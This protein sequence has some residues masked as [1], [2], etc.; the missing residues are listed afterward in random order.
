MG[1]VFGASYGTPRSRQRP[2]LPRTGTRLPP[3]PRWAPPC[4]KAG[5][6]GSQAAPG[7]QPPG[8][9]SRRGVVVIVVAGSARDARGAWSGVHSWRGARPSGARPCGARRAGNTALR[10][11]TGR[12]GRRAGPRTAGQA[13]RAT[14]LVAV[15]PKFGQDSHDVSSAGWLLRMPR[16]PQPAGLHLAAPVCRGHEACPAP[17]R[18]R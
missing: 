4:V 9:P 16:P 14:L 12:R 10:R 15:T 2:L 5:R 1:F 7:L 8:P 11:D 13:D 17:C 18:T 3:P 6:Q